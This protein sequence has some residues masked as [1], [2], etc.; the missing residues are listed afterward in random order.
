MVMILK[1]NNGLMKGYNI[2]TMN[3]M[4]PVEVQQNETDEISWYSSS[5]F[6]SG[7]L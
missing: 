4:I 1:I 3:V 7:G 5:C 6:R 2:S